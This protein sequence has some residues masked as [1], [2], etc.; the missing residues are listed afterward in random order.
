[1]KLFA[2][3][4]FVFAA[5][6]LAGIFSAFVFMQ[7]FHQTQLPVLSEMDLK[8]VYGL[9]L[10]IAFAKYRRKKETKERPSFES[11]IDEAGESVIH[12]IISTLVIWGL[13]YVALFF[14]NLLS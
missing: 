4:L 1:M 14:I 9:L 6:L 8:Q 10:V 2:Y 11:I 5:M 7:I 12:S 3:T 13:F